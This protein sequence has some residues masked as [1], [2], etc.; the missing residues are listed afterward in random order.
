MACPTHQQAA[1][2][3]G[4]EEILQ[5]RLELQEARELKKLTGQRLQEAEDERELLLAELEEQDKQVITST[6]QRIYESPA[7]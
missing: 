4:E 1:K 3:L 7:H 6:A 5:L 2:K